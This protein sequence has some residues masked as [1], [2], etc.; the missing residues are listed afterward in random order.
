MGDGSATT[1]MTPRVARVFLVA[2]I[3]GYT[4]YTARHGDLA[5]SRLAE[6]FA[7]IMAEGVTAWSGRMVELRGDEALAVFDEPGIALA[8]AVELQDAFG[9][10]T[11]A[12]PDAALPVGMGLDI[13][14]AVPVGEGYR[15]RA[16]NLAA[17]LCSVSRAGEVHAS[18]ELVRSAHQTTA[19]AF[20]PVSGLTLKGFG[21]DQRAFRVVSSA[22][23]CAATEHPPMQPQV[24]PGTLPREL[25]IGCPLVGREMEMRW[26]G[27]HWRRARHGHGRAVFIHGAAGVGKTRLLAELAAL[28]LRDGAWVSY[29]TGTEAIEPRV[30]EDKAG[31]AGVIIL[32]RGAQGHPARPPP[33]GADG[34]VL[35]V[36]AGDGGR[37]G[38]DTETAAPS[39]SW[40]SLEIRPLNLR[41]VR[42]LATI[43]APDLVDELPLGRILEDSGG[44]PTSA[45]AGIAEWV[46]RVEAERAAA[47]AAVLAPTERSSFVGRRQELAAAEELLRETRLLTLVGPPGTGKTRLA[48]RLF[49]ACGGRYAGGSWFVPLHAI[50]D[51]GLVGSAIA[52]V[53]GL[54]ESSDAAPLEV[55][56]VYLSGCE[57]LLVLDNF[58]QLLE[59]AAVVGQLLGAAP[60]LSIVVTSRSSLGISGEQLFSVPPMA[61]PPPG[62]PVR[63][64]AMEAYDAVALFAARAR[65]VDPGFT[66]D[67]TN[68]E[69]VGRITARLEGLPLAI[70]LAAARVRILS[71]PELLEHLDHR[72]PVLSAGGSAQEARHRTMRDAIAWSYELLSEADQTLLRRLAV[73]RGGFT[74][75]EAAQLA[76]RPEIETID[77][78]EALVTHSL[79]ARATATGRTRFSM[80]ELVREFAVD[81]LTARDEL[82]GASARHAAVILGL[83][84]EAGPELEGDGATAA[85]ARL[86]PEVDN[87]RAALEHA[88]ADEDAALGLRLSASV[89]RLWQSIGQLTEGREWLERCLRLDGGSEVDR[90]NAHGA[91]AG[92]A[93]WQGDFPTAREHY[94]QARGLFHAAG[95]RVEEAN[96]RYCLS[97]VAVLQGELDVAERY[98][99]QALSVFRELDLEGKVGEA[100]MAKTTVTW[101]KGDLTLARAYAEETVAISLR[102]GNRALAASQILGVAGVA[103]QQGDVATAVA[104]AAEGL[105]MSIDTS[106]THT[107]LFVL[108]AIAS[109]TV[110]R[111][112]V[113]A[114]RLCSAAAVLRE[115]HGGGWTLESFGIPSAREAA[116]GH[117]AQERIESSWQ[118]GHSLDLGAAIELGRS[119]V[120]QWSTSTAGGDPTSADERG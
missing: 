71:P 116:A 118:S 44:R 113:D 45:R 101:R 54:R 41:G 39:S 87:I 30:V 13:G 80:L 92:L 77:G 40:P 42:E 46:T 47:A 56:K 98:V 62:E 22:P 8:A 10:E 70:E 12:H 93:Y 64:E 43:M 29:R 28:A 57:G 18:I 52:R 37:H 59:A 26:L 69:T 15:G 65:A 75:E 114:V 11:S 102:L 4:A 55:A 48:L 85:L 106:N 66:L 86:T 99:D 51:P 68:A 49:A 100:L 53:L 9:H 110:V 2:D 3:R 119:L 117:L 17:R 61:C 104:K 35:L 25:D 81:E 33:L 60:G 38:D 108:D 73:F 6:R 105:E 34:R 95:D 36:V 82:A 111:A 83:V 115:K 97:L 50:R 24:P 90:A 63:T 32:D 78:V 21:P 16:L 107:Q 79:L 84:L 7:A 76:L 19:L 91:I 112:P 1:G 74:L 31:R 109:F 88:L 72:L 96:A 14:P 23:S 5:A 27:W 94:S 89:W 120:E 103:F 20:E 58:E 67:A